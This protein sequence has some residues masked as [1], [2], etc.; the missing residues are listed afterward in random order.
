M[1]VNLRISNRVAFTHWPVELG[2]SIRQWRDEAGSFGRILPIV[3]RGRV[4][5][6]SRFI[7]TFQR[8]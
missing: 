5:V 4:L 2:S 8:E 3:E 1:G 7:V 6:W